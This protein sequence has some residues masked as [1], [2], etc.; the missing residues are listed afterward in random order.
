[1]DRLK[2]MEREK[3]TCVEEKRA[4]ERA[5]VEKLVCGLSTNQECVVF[6]VTYIRM[7]L[8]VCVLV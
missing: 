6:H 4:K 5:H 3:K 2:E 1:M 8:C 7:L